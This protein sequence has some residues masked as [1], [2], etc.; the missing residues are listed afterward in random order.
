MNKEI[1]LRTWMVSKAI[2]RCS[3]TSYQKR[4][5]KGASTKEK[6]TGKKELN[7]KE[8]IFRLLFLY[9]FVN[10]TPVSMYFS[11]TSNIYIYIYI[12]IAVYWYI[13]VCVC[14]SKVKLATVDEG[15]QKDPFSI[16]TTVRV[17]LLSLDCSTLLSIRTL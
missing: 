13:C 11:H 3:F 16:A 14:V 12:Y 5:F 10:T 9:I 6:H 2:H 4:S 1:H 8:T 17:L 7:D 15:D